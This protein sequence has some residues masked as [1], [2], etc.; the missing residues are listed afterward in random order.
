MTTELKAAGPDLLNT[1]AY[2]TS[3]PTESHLSLTHE[4]QESDK[5]GAGVD[6]LDAASRRA[7]IFSSKMGQNTETHYKS[8]ALRRGLGGF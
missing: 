1:H 5:P 4:Q 2:K 6:A 7:K 8:F 3:G